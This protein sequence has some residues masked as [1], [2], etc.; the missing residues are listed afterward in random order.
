MEAPL[1]LKIPRANRHPID[2]SDDVPIDLTTPQLKFKRRSS[3]FNIEK[4][5]KEYLKKD[6]ENQKRKEYIKKLE[7]ERDNWRAIVNEKVEKTRE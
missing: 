3:F 7:D 2:L 6:E 1:N 5:P 4:A